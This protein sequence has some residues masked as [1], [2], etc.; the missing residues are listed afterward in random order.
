MKLI[1]VI[2]NKLVSIKNKI[3]YNISPVALSKNLYKK[4]FNKKL[5]LKNPNTFNEKIMWLKLYYCKDNK[6]VKKC[7]DKYRVRE[8]INEK[9]LDNIL[10]KLYGVYNNPKEINYEELPES[11][12][13]KSTSGSGNN[14]IIEDKKKI[15]V[16]KINKKLKRWKKEKY[17]EKFAETQYKGIDRNIICEEYLGKNIIDYKFF[18]FNGEPKFLYVSSGLGKKEDLYMEYLDMNFKSLGINRDGYKNFDNLIKP[19][20]FNKMVEYAKI[21]SKDFPFVRVDMYNINNNIYFSELTFV[22][23]GGLMKINPN[24]YDDI[25]GEYLDLNNIKKEIK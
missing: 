13:L 4:N 20:N 9:G 7:I 3:I 10:V 16:F 21:L 11:F 17:E 18:C 14:I 1:V 25:W 6:L 23:T 12:V 15:D 2:Y 22:P 24:K 8:Y 19:V 5:N